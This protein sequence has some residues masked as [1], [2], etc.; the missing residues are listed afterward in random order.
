MQCYVLNSLIREMP[1]RIRTL[2][3]AR[4]ATISRTKWVWF[5]RTENRLQNAGFV[6][7]TI[8]FGFPLR[9]VVYRLRFLSLDGISLSSH[10]LQVIPMVCFLDPVPFWLRSDPIPC[11]GVIWFCFDARPHC[12]CWIFYLLHLLHQGFLIFF[13]S[14]ILL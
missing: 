13:L 9:L 14:T 3:V 8:S 12:R 10:P 2:Q 1:A 7:V 11:C 6:G 5:V 4:H